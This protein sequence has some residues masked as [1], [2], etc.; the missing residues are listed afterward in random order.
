VG[1]ISDTATDAHGEHVRRVAAI[2]RAPIA[3]MLVRLGF[4]SSETAH[5]PN[6]AVQVLSALLAPEDTIE[7]CL[8]CHRI[9][10]TGPYPFAH[11]T[12][13]FA[14][15]DPDTTLPS[16]DVGWIPSSIRNYPAERSDIVLCT[17]TA[18]MWTRSQRRTDNNGDICDEVN[19]Y[20]VPFRDIL[21]ATVHS[22]R[23]GIVEVWIDEGP[24]LSIRTSR[25]EA[26]SLSS[27]IDAR[28]TAEEAA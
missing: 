10:S 6:A 7:L 13:L 14:R 27:H 26:I 20:A 8:T 5:R 1:D 9:T 2:R 24:N 19:L 12:G 28:A 4:I 16:D 17:Q 23:K 25:H 11:T 3:E 21:G 18:L 22:P 15:P